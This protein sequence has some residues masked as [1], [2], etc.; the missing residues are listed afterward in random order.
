MGDTEIIRQITE[1]W[2]AKPFLKKMQAI[3]YEFCA[4]EC[5]KLIEAAH[6]LAADLGIILQE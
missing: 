3:G 6:V 4:D 2:L 1:K 5:A